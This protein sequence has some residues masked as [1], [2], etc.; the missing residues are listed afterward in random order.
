MTASLLLLMTLASAGPDVRMIERPGPP[1]AELRLSLRGGA[2]DD[3]PH[4]SGLA[5]VAALTLEARLTRLDPGFA[6]HLGRVGIVARAGARSARIERLAL[7]AVDALSK[8]LSDSEVDAA[9]SAAAGARRRFVEDDR[10]LAEAELLRML[11]GDA[12]RNMLGTVEELA[13]VTRDDVASFMRRHWRADNLR[14]VLAGR[15]D[16]SISERIHARAAGLDR[17]ATDHGTPSRRSPVDGEAMRV[18][19]VDKPGRRRALVLLGKATALSGPAATV[20]DAAI[21]G[22]LTSP[23]TKVVQAEPPVAEYAFSTLF[24]DRWTLSVWTRPERIPDAVTRLMKMLAD[25]RADGLDEQESLLGKRTAASR[26]IL[27][28]A[29]AAM[30]ADDAAR[31]WLLRQGSI[32]PERYLDLKPEEISAAA[33]ALVEREGLAVVIVASA[34]ADLLSKLVQVPGVTDVKVVRYDLR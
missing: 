23:A 32:G 21:G 33:G 17:P 31:R 6:V 28:E 24:A 26:L 18:L 29:D 3:P 1:W 9:V 34:T 27:S 10:A 13:K 15:F 5:H 4:K 11:F 19:L 12:G 16:R 7:K 2:N 25:I 30:A 22:A 20:A 8:P 14:I